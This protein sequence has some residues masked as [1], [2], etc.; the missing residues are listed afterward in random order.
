[1]SFFEELK[2]R[3]VVRVGLAYAVATWL[4]IQVTDIVFPRIGL[5]DSAVT[6]VIAL[7]GIG[8]IPALIFAWAFEMTPEGIRREREVD[9]SESITPKTGKKLDRLIIATLGLI[10]AW[11][12]VDEFWLEPREAVESAQ[13]QQATADASP[14][15]PESTTAEA[16][17]TT[18]KSVAVLPFRSMS[19][20]E[21]DEYFADGLTEEILNSLAALQELNVTARTSS[22]HFKGKDQPVTEI[23]EILG[24]AHIVEGSVR[25]AKD[26][27]R[28][29]AQ[30]VRTNDGFHLWSQTYDR[31]LEDVF[32]VQEDIATNIA[33]TLDVLL[34]DDQRERMREA[35]IGNV[36]AFIAFQKGNAANNRAHDDYDNLL[37]ILGEANQWYD[38]ALEIVPDFT[39]AHLWR[40]DYFQHVL[41]DDAVGSQEAT[42]EVLA[43]AQLEIRNSLNRALQSAKTEAWRAVI[44]AEL[45]LLS[46]D[47]SK[48]PM[49]LEKAYGNGNCVPNNWLDSL[50]SPL[51]FEEQVFRHGQVM[52][53]CNPLDRQTIS[54]SLNALIWAN[55]P[56]EAI[57]A[58]ENQLVQYG[59]S[60][61]FEE[62]LFHARM[63]TGQFMDDP[64]FFEPDTSGAWTVPRPV[65]AYAFAGDLATSRRLYKEYLEHNEI[66]RWDQL[67]VAVVH[68]EREEANRL[69]AIIDSRPGHAIALLNTVA[70][71]YCGAPFDL[72][73]TPNFKQKIESAGF[74]WPPPSPVKYPAKDW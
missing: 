15:S 64:G 6:L 40:T 10:V 53:Q 27:V 3:N 72:D 18:N 9:R 68:G 11:F 25:R 32:A 70:N 35:G 46:D 56:E 47:W 8:F 5:P 41:R 52:E 39:D 69:A 55:R 37:E 17:E 23:G 36:E 22:F 12:L 4:L 43:D 29:T 42:P 60:Q 44:E 31:T 62:T 26:Q 20:G 34:D 74:T 58:A 21:D 48:L 28:I 57:T 30:L 66:D 45:Q 24:V 61:W 51:G 65:V 1:M 2:R 19:S 59:Y 54:F 50:M 49:R 67:M 63:A 71:C 14:V 13:P 33:E 73:A 16:V 7:L 38:K